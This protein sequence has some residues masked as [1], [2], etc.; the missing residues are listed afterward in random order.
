LIAFS[1]T[2]FYA[3]MGTGTGAYWYDLSSV[4]VT[5]LFDGNWHH[6]ALSVFETG[7]NLYIDGSLKYQYSYSNGGV[8]NPTTGFAGTSPY[9]I[10]KF[11]SSGTGYLGQKI[12]ELSFFDKKITDSEVLQIYNNGKPSD[13]SS[14]S[15]KQWWR[16]GENAYFDNN[17]FTVPNSIAGAPNGVGFGTVT[18]ML[19]ADAPGTY[20]NG[21]GDGLAIT[22]R[23]GDAPLSVANSQ[24]YN[25]IP[26]DKVPYVPGYVGA[27]T[28]NAYSMAFDGTNYF[29][30]GSSI[31]LGQ[32]NT[33]SFWIYYPAN[34]FH[35][36]TG[37]PLIGNNYN[38][39]LN[40]GNTILYRTTTGYNTWSVSPT[41]NAW[42]HLAFTKNNTDTYGKM[43]FNGVE[44]SIG[45]GSQNIRYGV[46]K[47]NTIGAKP[48]GTVGFV[49]KLDE[50][51]VFDKEL[52]ADQI[53]FDLYEPTTT[54]KTA[55]IENNTNLPTPV[56]WYRMGD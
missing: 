56:A 47:F 3:N 52:T 1:G 36:V 14:L 16:L 44:Q 38:I 22:D 10:N 30:L 19:S 12:D 29:S 15:P 23:V 5:E 35:I 40:N 6:I 46:T 26:D 25:M 34:G 27:Q 7:Q 13:I 49:G 32:T 53:K 48:N 43:Y 21:I 39:F 45:S 8:S 54:G 2:N 41:L 28:T 37:D 18:T 11:G 9:Y 31:D 50:F 55:D 24:S 33:I 17:S 51:A 20:A 42:T 4:S